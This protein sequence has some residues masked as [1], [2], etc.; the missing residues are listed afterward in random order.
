MALAEDY[1][2]LKELAATVSDPALSGTVLPR[3]PI[4]NANRLCAHGPYELNHRR[5][6]DR[7]A[8]KNQVSRRR[9]VWERFAQLL[10]Y[11]R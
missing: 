8:V 9:V 3:A 5:A 2:M 11:P 1:D 6:E 4:R 7:V 10:N